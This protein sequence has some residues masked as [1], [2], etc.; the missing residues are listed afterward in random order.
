MANRNCGTRGIVSDKVKPEIQ[1]GGGLRALTG[2][3]CEG[4]FPDNANIP[5]IAYLQNPTHNIFRS[6]KISGEL[7]I[8][9]AVSLREEENVESGASSYTCLPAALMACALAMPSADWLFG[10]DT[11]GYWSKIRRTGVMCVQ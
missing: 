3:R 7:R 5:H 10:K 2:I 1:I 11:S 6:R 9:P 4:R 8:R